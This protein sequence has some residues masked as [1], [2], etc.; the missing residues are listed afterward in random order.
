MGAPA[1]LDLQS[2]AVLQRMNAVTKYLRNYVHGAG[3]TNNSSTQGS[4]A[5]THPDLNFN[6]AAS[7]GVV[8]G[9]PQVSIAAATD[10]DSIG[11][12]QIT[13]GAT[14][15]KEVWVAVV[16]LTNGTYKMVAG[17]VASTAVGAVVATEAQITA[18]VATANWTMVGDVKVTRT[19]DT[20]LT[21]GT[22]DYSRRNDFV[23]FPLALSTTEAENRV[24]S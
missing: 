6:V 12:D 10:V 13:F 24:V 21:I 16:M 19:A 15:A 11:G 22:P 9:V 1:L 20:A 23:N 4:G 5:S 8:A 14:S 2:L 3:I 18:Q 17:T 7:G